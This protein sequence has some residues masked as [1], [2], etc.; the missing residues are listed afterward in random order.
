MAKT[1]VVFV[2]N[3]CGK[4]SLKWSGR[5]PSCDAWNTLVES[6]AV[7][8]KPATRASRT[9]S[10]LQSLTTP[11]AE[12]HER[13][14][15]TIGELN[16][17][18]GGGLTRGSLVLIGGE[19]GIGKSTL[20]L[21]VS[22]GI[23][24]PKTPVVYVSG[25]ET[26]SQLKARAKRL[27][28]PGEGLYILSE[29]DVESIIED[30]DKLN[31]SLVVIDSIQTMSLDGIETSP[32]SITQVREC[33]I[34][35]MNWAKSAQIPVFITG[36]VT[37]E[38]AIAGPRMLE[39][40]VDTVLYFEGES[41]SS[42]RILRAA[43]N[44]Y[45]STNEVGLFEM[46]EKGLEEVKN[47][48]EVFL[49]RDREDTIGSAVVPVLEGSRPL[50]VE[51]QALVSLNNYGSPRRVAAGVDFNRLLIISAVLSKRANLKLGNHDIVVSVTGGLK[52]DEPAADLA[53]ALAI[54]SS[55]KNIGVDETLVAVGEVGLSG[56]I[57]SVTQLER[58][59][60]EAARLGFKGAIVPR[61]ARVKSPSPDF[62][63]IPVGNIFQAI[64]VGL[65]GRC[66]EE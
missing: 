51:I 2:C 12:N 45:G 13:I 40:I 37:K 23:A 49:T 46:K 14:N 1:R 50:C 65:V 9:A 6:V 15:L 10:K 5:C 7:E 26:F 21:Q 29:T 60:A 55:Y 27:G 48:S 38:G 17:V 24:S 3:A 61:T 42:Y 36:H 43:K 33:T 66:R 47:P 41:V 59:L 25:E 53:L 16:R 63:L 35:L 30:I 11:L 19:P 62:K 58:R 44:R 39:H 4:E 52:L 34:R 8:N 22:A 28:L 64:G 32:G 31:A 54:A 18:L 56:E 57:R 20:L